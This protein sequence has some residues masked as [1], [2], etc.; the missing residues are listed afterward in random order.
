MRERQA[1]TDHVSRDC[2]IPGHLS[3]ESGKF[4]GSN[5]PNGS[6]SV[7]DM[8]VTQTC[9]PAVWW[10]DSRSGDLWV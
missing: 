3:A 9:A 5:K 8:L 2:S 6:T 10:L 1:C 7:P 4:S